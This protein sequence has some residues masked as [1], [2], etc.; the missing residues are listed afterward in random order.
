MSEIPKEV[1]DT[2]KQMQS[3]R[4]TG[5]LTIHMAQGEIRSLDQRRSIRVIGPHNPCDERRSAS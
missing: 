2:L 5:S 3:E 4:Y 1:D